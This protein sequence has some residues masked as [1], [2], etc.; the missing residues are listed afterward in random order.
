M[1][2]CEQGACSARIPFRVHSTI[3]APGLTVAYI[4]R[5]ADCLGV[6]V[7]TR[8]SA[9][10]TFL[11]LRTRVSHMRSRLCFVCFFPLKKMEESFSSE[12]IL[13]GDFQSSWHYSTAS[14]LAHTHVHTYAHRHTCMHTR[15][16][17]GKHRHKYAHRHTWAHTGTHRHK[18]AHRHTCVHTQAHMGTHRGTHTCTPLSLPASLH[19]ATE[20]SVRIIDWRR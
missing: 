18:H 14:A 11:P 2:R 6:S 1:A 16:H 7:S 4:L 13:P 10:E 20:A 8:Q 5:S 3:P 15:A 12:Q 19:F 9:V 17:A